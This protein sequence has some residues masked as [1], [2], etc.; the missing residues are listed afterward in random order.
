MGFPGTEQRADVADLNSE[1]RYKRFAAHSNTVAGNEVLVLEAARR[2]ADVDVFGLNPGFVKTDIRANLLG[3]RALVSLINW[4]TSFMMVEPDVYA[5][6]LV[7]LVV[8][9]DLNGR[10]G[11]M[12][13][14]KA[15]GI[16][17]S[18]SSAERSYATALM[19]ASDRLIARLAP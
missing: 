2:L 5:E 7:P 10:S 1:R 11:A 3:S 17:P 6:R 16:L 18:P 12:F 14:N 13:N 8:S 19:D 9:P 4:L 15:E